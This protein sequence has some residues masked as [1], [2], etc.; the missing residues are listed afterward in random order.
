MSPHVPLCRWTQ[1]I[2]IPTFMGRFFQGPK[3]TIQL[4]HDQNFF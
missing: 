4:V 2:P 1:N 3:H